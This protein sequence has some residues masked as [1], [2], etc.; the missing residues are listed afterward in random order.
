M[1]WAQAVV[2]AFD[3]VVD[4]A[5]PQD[6]EPGYGDALKVEALHIAYWK[7]GGWVG[8]WVHGKEAG[9]SSSTAASGSATATGCM[10]A[11]V[12]LPGRW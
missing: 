9:C 5:V 12:R 7:V 10:A 2:R 8:G 11:R 1:R 4:L 3:Q 6:Y